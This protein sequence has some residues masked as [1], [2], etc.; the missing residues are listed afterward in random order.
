[1]EWYWIIG[2]IVILVVIVYMIFFKKRVSNE[3]VKKGD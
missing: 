1:M 2:I 3:K